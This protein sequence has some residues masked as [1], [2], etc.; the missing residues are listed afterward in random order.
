MRVLPV[1]DSKRFALP[2]FS[3]ALIRRHAFALSSFAVATLLGVLFWRCLHDPRIPVE[4]PQAVF[5]GS[6]VLYGASLYDDLFL[7]GYSMKSFQFSA[8]T[9]WVPDLAIYFTWRTILGSVAPA[10]WATVL[11]LFLFHLG[12]AV[13]FGRS[14]VGVTG[15][16]FVGPLVVLT[17]G[18]YLGISVLNNFA[19]QEER[20]IYLPGYHGGAALLAYLAFAAVVRVGRSPNRWGIVPSHLASIVVVTVAAVVSDRFYGLWFVGP[21]AVGVIGTKLLARDESFPLTW[22][23]VLVLGTA[24]ALGTA[25]GMALLKWVLSTAGDPIT[26][27]WVGANWGAFLDQLEL[28]ARLIVGEC[29]NGNWLTISCVLWNAG[30]LLSIGRAFVRRL[31]GRASETDGRFLL[32]HLAGFAM[33]ATTVLAFLLSTASVDYLAV[34]DWGDMSRYFTGPISVGLFGWAFLLARLAGSGSR[35]VREAA[36]LLPLALTVGVVVALSVRNPQPEPGRNLVDFRPTY[37]DE[38]DAICLKYDMKD[39]LSA[40][41][42]AKQTTLFSRAGVKLRPIETVSKAPH[43]ITALHWLS[44]S[45]Y[46]WKA[47]RGRE[48]P[49]K[50]EFIV[51]HPNS[52]GMPTAE[53]MIRIFGEPAAREKAGGH[54]V[55]I[56]NRPSD[57]KL[58]RFA[59]LDARCITLKA[60]RDG[61][62]KITYPGASLWGQRPIS[63]DS[64]WYDRTATEQ[65]PQGVLAFGP[66]LDRL[67]PG[68]YK[69]TFRTS[70]T[71]VTESNGALDVM[72]SDLSKGFEAVVALEAVPVGADRETSVIAYVSNSAKQPRFEFRTFY[73][74]KGA[75]TLHDVTIEKLGPGSRRL[76]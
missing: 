63:N 47:P 4:L 5:F 31:R 43:G 38:I 18:I 16:R 37:L 67:T 70:T 45:E 21:V 46:Y 68:R 19:H 66:Y 56:Y 62:E 12:A 8:A 59:E 51:A 55:L 2:T 48:R 17:G 42:L 10:M 54:D 69:I 52:P 30:A 73:S 57:F 7:D 49:V 60:N 72:Y 33:T 44:N 58:H 65:T 6:D 74:G 27:Y 76:R 15:S 3:F 29:S 34:L 75:L 61:W 9:F 11:T 26:N 40:Y 50:F 36:T 64:N 23:K 41:A 25:A 35:S 20:E 71:G 39:G 32:F 28:F 13:R 14:L 53:E 24:V 1:L 22:R